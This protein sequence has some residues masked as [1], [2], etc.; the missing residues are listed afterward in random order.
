MIYKQ[1][2]TKGQFISASVYC[3]VSEDFE[4]DKVIFTLAGDIEWEKDGRYNMLK[5]GVWQKLNLKAVYNEGYS[6][7]FLFVEKKVYDSV[8]EEQG[9]II[10]AYPTFK[11]TDKYEFQPEDPDGNWASGVYEIKYPLTGRFVELV[12]Q[13]AQGLQITEYS[14]NTEWNDVVLNH[15]QNQILINDVDSGEYVSASILCYVSSDFSGKSVYLS[16]RGDIYGKPVNYFNLEMKDQWQKL[17][18]NAMCKDGKA[19][20]YATVTSDKEHFHNTGMSGHVI[21]AYPQLSSEKSLLVDPKKIPSHQE[22][23]RQKIFFPLKGSMLTDNSYQA[24]S[25]LFTIPGMIN[26]YST[27]NDADPIRR[28]AA[29]LISEDTTYYPFHAEL[30]VD[31]IGREFGED[32]I[33]RWKF[34]LEIFTK[35]F[36]PGQ[37]IFG[38]GFDFLGW[39]GH[40]FRN[41]HL[42]IDYPH[43][44]FLFILL[45]SGV[46]GLTLYLLFLFIA[47]KLYMKYFKEYFL[48]FGMFLIIFY[49]VLFSSGNPFNPPMMGFFI[50]LPFFIHAVIKRNTDENFNDRIK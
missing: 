48:L 13:Q 8:A 50:L 34:A 6:N 3:F 27:S 38:G 43:N 20:V 35:E 33:M 11:V 44:P 37:K 39:Y 7:L 28:M 46:T 15:I 21:F 40:V 49:F 4:A 25:F 18:V 32:R 19:G 2:V 42:F 31:S 12:P 14:L 1:I 30:Y 22:L 26:Q 10:F 17:N 23:S 5:K 9:R 41:D 16:L 45:Y 24:S 47:I 29:L 36:D